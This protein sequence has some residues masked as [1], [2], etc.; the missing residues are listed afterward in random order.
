MLAAALRHSQG[1]AAPCANLALRQCL[2][3]IHWCLEPWAPRPISARRRDNPSPSGE[4]AISR[5]L[6]IEIITAA[7]S[8]DGLIR[9]IEQ[10]GWFA[11]DTEFVGEDQHRPE[12]CLIQVATGVPTC[13]LIDPLSGLDVRPFWELVANERILVIVHAGG[14]DVGLCQRELQRP[15][16]NVFDLQIAAGMVGHGYPVS[17][18]RLAKMTTRRKI[19][20]SQTLSDWRKRPLSA[21]QIEYAVEDV[22]CLRAMY[23]R[24]HK[25]LVGLEREAWAATECDK[26][27][28][29]AGGSEDEVQKLKRL[30]GA[31]GLSRRELGIAHCLLD[32]RE[33]LAAKYNRPART[34]LKDHI[35]VEIAKRGWTDPKRI[36]SIRG[37]NVGV[38]GIRLLAEFV[39]A[40]KDL[41]V[42]QL[43]ELPSQ[44]DTP[45]E[46]VL[47]SLLA[48]VLRDYCNRSDLAFSLVG[49]KQ[50]LRS[51]IRTYTRGETAPA[52]HPLAT[53]WRKEA[54]GELLRSI[55]AG[56]RIVRVVKEKGEMRLSAE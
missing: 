11:F 27:C 16:A 31:G 47:L 26:L 39:Q 32:A 50:D 42:E 40:G 37:I 53:G 4:T 10:H 18:S 52:D 38:S 20:K 45:Q 43:P 15:G 46:D 55:L 29:T 33:T 34:I 21:E 5:E 6:K 30:R 24:I 48:A 36:Q 35:L 1:P 3:R 8:L 44:E 7:A 17:L 49:K 19:H 51:L 9:V 22:V 12:V 2:A 23:D 41:P 14:E 54:V 28:L 56:E 13:Y 25:R